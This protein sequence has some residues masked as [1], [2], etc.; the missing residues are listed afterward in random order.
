[1]FGDFVC[2]IG[3][4]SFRAHYTREGQKRSRARTCPTGAGKLCAVSL[5]PG[6][7]DIWCPVSTHREQGM[8]GTLTVA[9]ANF[10]DTQSVRRELT[11]RVI[12][13]D[14]IIDEAFG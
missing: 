7:Y 5:A 10:D 4:V 1:M 13:L 6:T 3:A 2:S 11:R 14:P 9:G 12:A 8:V